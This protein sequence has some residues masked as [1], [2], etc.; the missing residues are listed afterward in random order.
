[1]LM[2][3]VATIIVVAFF[4]YYIN[5]KLN[6]FKDRGITQG[7]PMFLFGH[8]LG[9]IIHTQTWTDVVQSIYDQSPGTRYT[10]MYNFYYPLLVI[11]DPELLKQVAIK[12]FDH[13]TDH[14]TFMPTDGDPLFSKSLFALQGREWREMRTLLSPCFTSSKMKFMFNLIIEISENFAQYFLKK[15]ED[16]IE[17]EMKNALSRFSSDVIATTACGIQV[18]SL[19]N[20]NNQFYLMGQKSI[21]FGGIW[22][23][24]KFFLYMLV[25]PI[26]NIMKIQ[27]FTD[28]VSTFFRGLIDEAIKVREEKGIVRPDMIHIL[29]ETRKGTQKEEETND[30]DTGFA[31]AQESP[32]SLEK[33]KVNKVLTNEEITAQALIFF[34]A[35]F[36][37]VSSVM[38]FTTYELTVNQDV[39]ERL[40]EEVYS[41]WKAC[42]GKL[43][44]DAL[45]QMKY[46]DMVISETLRKYPI[47]LVIERVCTKPYTIEPVLPG[48]IPV[49]LKVN[50]AIWLPVYAIHHDPNYYPNPDRFDPDRFSDENK[51]DIKPYT[52]L[53]F[54]LGPRNC[55]GSRF[56][57]LMIKAVIFHTLLH[58]ELV[59]I[60]KT[61][62]PLKISKKSFAMNAEGG[63]WLGFKKTTNGQFT[64]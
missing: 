15:D 33:G 49:D 4:Y 23:N 27:L 7:K 18:D 21:D 61:V 64:T 56:A 53:P 52:Y 14:I 48:E 2:I 59:P 51:G 10:G 42:K 38:C 30:V 24:I 40:R 25:P 58:F 1:M 37:S 3:I 35:G 19:E 62:I 26:K 12:D 20:P 54:G 45:L 39:Q 36:D 17:V 55:I 8:T 6:Y 22:K 9:A 41:T 57:L 63:F 29:L 28:D 34:I 16:V 13:F 60:E 44:Y 32:R 50:D 31:T 43:T 11:K 46:L 47:N 5:K